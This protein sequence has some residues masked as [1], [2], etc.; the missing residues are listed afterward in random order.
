MPNNEMALREGA[1]SQTRGDLVRAGTRLDGERTQ[2]T[3]QEESQGRGKKPAEMCEL[4]LTEQTIFH[5]ETQIKQREFGSTTLAKLSQAQV[6]PSTGKEKCPLSPTLVFNVRLNKICLVLKVQKDHFKTFQLH[7]KTTPAYIWL[8]LF[9]KL[10]T[11]SHIGWVNL[12]KKIFHQFGI[13]VF[14]FFF[15]IYGTVRRGEEGI[16]QCSGEKSRSTSTAQSFSVCVKN[17]SCSKAGEGK[18][19]FSE[20]IS[21]DRD[22]YRCHVPNFFF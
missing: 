2:Q 8:K 16:S 17:Q 3:L 7:V 9:V 5:A 4:Q 19:R 21:I 11:N 13:F 14:F 6:A 22:N 10:D 20:S 18:L 1:V 15:L 12:K